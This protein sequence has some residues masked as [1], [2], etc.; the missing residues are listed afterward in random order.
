MRPWEITVNLITN[1]NN[2]DQRT[3]IIQIKISIKFVV[4]MKYIYL[5]RE[6]VIFAFFI[7]SLH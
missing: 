4:F 2:D 7:E 5:L 6:N 1:P 3:I